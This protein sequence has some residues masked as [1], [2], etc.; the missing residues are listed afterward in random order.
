MEEF[1]ARW[2]VFLAIDDSRDL[3]YCNLTWTDFLWSSLYK[4]LHRKSVQLYNCTMHS[5]G[6]FYNS[7]VFL[8]SLD[9]SM[10]WDVARYIFFCCLFKLFGLWVG[11]DLSLL[12]PGF[13]TKSRRARRPF[14]QH[15][16]FHRA[17]SVIKLCK[18]VS[19]SKFLTSIIDIQ[20]Q[21]MLLF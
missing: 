14:D 2:K 11:L 17:Q 10:Q 1:L 5:D 20:H 6:K 21:N 18:C 8:T 13:F 12:P 7:F 4:E 16:D 19:L 15:G 3:F 9:I